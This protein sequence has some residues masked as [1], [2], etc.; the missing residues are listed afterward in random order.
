VGSHGDFVLPKWTW[1][2]TA[3]SRPMQQ[4]VT[5]TTATP[6]GQVPM[7]MGERVHGGALGVRR[8][9]T[10][11]LFEEGGVKGEV[12]SFYG[13][14]VNCDIHVWSHRGTG[15]VYS[16]RPTRRFHRGR[17]RATRER[18]AQSWGHLSAQKISVGAWDRTVTS[19]C[20]GRPRHL[21]LFSCRD[22][23]ID[24]M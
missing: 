17:V 10:P 11:P 19:S 24:I 18:C 4:S 3:Y 16:L 5:H 6:N 2:F 9:T 15:K 20:P 23:D 1:T 21:P 12:L 8:E 22:R 7:R 14:A 13:S